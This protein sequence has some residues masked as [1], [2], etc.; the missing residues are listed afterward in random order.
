MERS[1]LFHVDRSLRSENSKFAQLLNSLD[2]KKGEDYLKSLTR[3][4]LDLS[5][6]VP[7]ALIS[8]P[9][10]LVLGIVKKLED[11]GSAFFVQERMAR[12]TMKDTTRLVKIRCM[13]E[14]SDKKEENIR[15][16]EK[17]APEDD[18]RNTRFGKFMRKFQL[19]ELPQLFQ[20]IMNDLSLIGIRS[21]PSYA[22]NYLEETWGS[23]RYENFLKFYKLCGGA[24]ID[25]AIIFG[26]RFV[27]GEEINRYHSY[28]FYSK[29]ASLGLDLYL[30][31]KTFLK[32]TKL[33]S[34]FN[35]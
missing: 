3:R 34:K 10:I 14:N 25:V 35:K 6:A 13:H 30:L 16:S 27:K 5:I 29:N 26:T 23:E 4:G 28:A 8:T 33:S 31:W 2:P 11:G 21:T 22:L 1:I 19:E 12:N 15:I 7:A 17:L 20:I 32:L 18:P 9:L 24:L